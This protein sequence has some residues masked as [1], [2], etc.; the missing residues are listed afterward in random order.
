MGTIAGCIMMLFIAAAGMILSHYVDKQER[1][2]KAA[3]KE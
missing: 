1:K 2:E 3:H